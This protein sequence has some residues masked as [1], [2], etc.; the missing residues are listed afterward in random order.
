MT[1][2]V[3]LSLTEADLVSNGRLDE[4]GFRPH[5]RSEGLY[6]GDPDEFEDDAEE[7]TE[8]SGKEESGSVNS[9][10]H[11]ATAHHW[12]RYSYEKAILLA[13]SR[14]SNELAIIGVCVAAGGS[15]IGRRSGARHLLVGP[16]VLFGIS[17]RASEFIDSLPGRAKPVIRRIF[18]EGHSRPFPANLS[19]AVDELLRSRVPDYDQILSSLPGPPTAVVR[20]IERPAVVDA[21]STALR[22]FSR[23]WPALEPVQ[24]GPVSD[25]SISI[26]LAAKGSEDDYITD[27]STYFLDWDRSRISQGGWWE[28]RKDGRRLHLKNINV[29]SAENTTGADLVYVRREPDTVVLVQYKLLEILKREGKPIFRPDNR[30]GGQITRM[31]GFCPD[32]ADRGSDESLARIGGDF[33]FIKFILPVDG[34]AS[35]SER[36][37][38]R[39]FPADAVRRMLA[40]PESGPND[41]VVHF[42]YDRRYMDGE[43]FAKLVRDRWI[44]SSGDVTDR[45][46]GILGL[47]PTD[48]RQP[49]TLAIEETLA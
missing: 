44:G 49:I 8:V 29:S 27:D 2:I 11:V 25:F 24:A 40:N 6:F 38:G 31:L 28:F 43:T 42:V 14:I 5:P 10:Q 21:N 22:I 46:L 12:K 41:G 20:R 1:A 48:E 19:S 16:W 9:L 32:S 33:C 13:P 18:N 39:Y 15:R 35:I 26:E 23:N 4:P 3:F 36:P 37:H 45:I 47:R 34:Y 7:E 17:I 30:L